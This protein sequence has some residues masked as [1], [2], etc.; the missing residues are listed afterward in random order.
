MS[1]SNNCT[2]HDCHNKSLDAGFVEDVPDVGCNSSKAQS[3]NFDEI[4]TGVK[5]YGMSPLCIIGILF[6]IFSIGALF[7]NKL[8]LRKSLIQMFILL[9]TS[10][11]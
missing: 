4:K 10:D 6:N 11:A 7:S 9:N 3:W 8:R 1:S 5:M 2:Q